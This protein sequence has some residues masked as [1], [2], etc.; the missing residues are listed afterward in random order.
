MAGLTCNASLDS[1]AALHQDIAEERSEVLTGIERSWSQM[2]GF[3]AHVALDSHAAVQ[4][5]KAE[6]R[7]EV[8]SGTEGS[9]Y[10]SEVRPFRFHKPAYLGPLAVV[11]VVV[12]VYVAGFY[13]PVYTD[14]HNFMRKIRSIM[15][16]L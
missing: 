4:Q 13:K 5:D 10:T 2:A 16:P 14:Y 9:P 3:T 8:L 11:H 6:E 7:T 15:R 1:H 12:V